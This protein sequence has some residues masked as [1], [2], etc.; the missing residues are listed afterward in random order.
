M[1]KNLSVAAASIFVHEVDQRRI[2]AE[3]CRRRVDCPRLLATVP[4]SLGPPKHS[5]GNSMNDLTLKR[6]GL[7]RGLDRVHKRL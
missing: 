7:A 4:A 6:Q 1:R 2:D 5:A 3:S